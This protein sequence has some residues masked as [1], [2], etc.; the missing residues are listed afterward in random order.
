ME[1][2]IILL[3]I[4]DRSFPEFLIEKNIGKHEKI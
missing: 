4:I 2:L 1:Y 3:I